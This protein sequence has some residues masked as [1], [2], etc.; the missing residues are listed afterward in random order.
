MAQNPIEKPQLRSFGL[1]VASGFSVIAL[2]PT[3]LRGDSPRAWALTIAA[4]LLAFG[5]LFPRGLRPVYKIWMVAGAVLGWVNTR[6]ILG[7]VFYLLIVPM[8][9]CLRL[10]KKDPMLRKFDANAAS[11]K[12]PRSKRPPSH[13]QHQY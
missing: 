3:L 9:V 8:S 7:A 1:I 6:I 10:A 2:L 5:L 12:I 13:M 4:V 11:Y